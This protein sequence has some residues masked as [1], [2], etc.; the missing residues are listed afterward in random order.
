MQKRF[1]WV[2]ILIVT[3][4]ST[5]ILPNHQGSKPD[6]I[7][8]VKLEEQ[9]WDEADDTPGGTSPHSYQHSGLNTGLFHF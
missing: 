9:S 6:D 7:Q 8:V 3:F 4:T 5:Y 2:S 1:L